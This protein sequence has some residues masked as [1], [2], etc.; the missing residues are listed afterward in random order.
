MLTV[1]SEQA[2]KAIKNIM[3]G[4]LIAMDWSDA[5]VRKG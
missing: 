2:L 1:L 3:P 4:R 5:S